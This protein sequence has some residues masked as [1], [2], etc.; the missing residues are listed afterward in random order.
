VT[1]S[2]EVAPTGEHSDFG[3]RFKFDKVFEAEVVAIN[4]RRA[5]N[6][7]QP[8]ELE[9]EARDIAGGPVMAPTRESDL[10]GLAFS[11]GGIRSAGSAIGCGIPHNFINTRRSRLGMISSAGFAVITTSWRTTISSLKF[12]GF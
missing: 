6:G 11:G 12:L 1:A 3:A 8:I 5:A 10:A 7:R 4:T 2:T 9:P